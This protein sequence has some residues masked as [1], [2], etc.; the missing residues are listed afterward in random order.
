MFVA[1]KYLITFK[2]RI[3]IITHYSLQDNDIAIIFLETPVPG[4]FEFAKLP[5][6]GKTFDKVNAETLG[7]GAIHTKG[8]TIRYVLCIIR[9]VRI[10]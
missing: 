5:D 6:K 9:S 1:C 4:D 10:L 8:G 7:W 3:I 2:I